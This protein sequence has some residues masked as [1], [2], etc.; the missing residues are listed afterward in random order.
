MIEANPPDQDKK[1]KV[2]RNLDRFIIDQINQS[3]FKD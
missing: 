1:Q 3:L 2:F